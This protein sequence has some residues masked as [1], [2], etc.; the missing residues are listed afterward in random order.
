MT[1]KEGRPNANASQNARRQTER[2]SQGDR[3]LDVREAAAMLAVKPATLYQWAYQRRI[4]VVKLFGAR[5]AL[6]FRLSDIQRLVAE[7]VRP[8]LRSSEDDAALPR[9]PRARL[10]RAHDAASVAPGTGLALPEERRTD[11]TTER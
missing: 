1:R 2:L 9:R 5:G 11:D 7:S 4:P 3:L 6:R 10:A 8:P